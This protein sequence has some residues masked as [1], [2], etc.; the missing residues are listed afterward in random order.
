MEFKY[1][2]LIEEKTSLSAEITKY[3]NQLLNINSKH[4]IEKL[5]IDSLSKSMLDFNNKI[6][7]LNSM[8]TDEKF[9]H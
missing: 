2:K 4:E 8:L 3:K 6:N 1:K 9:K 7:E 5:K